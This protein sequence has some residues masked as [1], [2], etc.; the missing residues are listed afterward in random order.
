MI[1]AKACWYRLP[2]VLTCIANIQQYMFVCLFLFF[3][4]LRLV[5]VAELQE[6]TESMELALFQNL[7]MRH[8]DSAKERLLK[9]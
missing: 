7:V 1:V 4:K 8:I 3:S 6:K 2:N 5:D 9:K